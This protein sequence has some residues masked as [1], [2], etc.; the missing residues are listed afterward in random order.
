[1][2]VVEEFI[3]G[4]DGEVRLVKLRTASGVMLRPIQRVLPLEIYE[5][6]PP[7]SDQPAVRVAQEAEATVVSI[8]QKDN[9]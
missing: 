4:R 7:K 2:A 5:E 1:L 9:G 3:P 8:G 6:E